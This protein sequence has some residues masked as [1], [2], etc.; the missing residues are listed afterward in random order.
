VSSPD[1]DTPSVEVGKRLRVLR[2]ERRISLRELGRLSGISVNAL[3]LIERGMTSP[4]V[5]T[6]YRLVEALGVPI[7]A[8]FRTEPLREEIV[9]IPVG[10]R[11][12]VPFPL[13]LWEGLGGESFVGRL[14]PFMLTLEIGAD[15]GAQ[16]IVHTGHEFVMCLQGLLEYTVEGKK[17]ILRQGDSLLFAARLRHCWR[18]TGNSVTKAIFVLSGFEEFES[19]GAFHLTT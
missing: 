4:S 15:S 5:S 12:L 8:I 17:Y 9:F 14:Q 10:E 6:L 19:P 1:H 2:A 7:T 11:T 3:S 18:N 16:A 13:G